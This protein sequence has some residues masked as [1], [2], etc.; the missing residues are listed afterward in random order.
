MRLFLYELKKIWRLPLLLIIA[1]ITAMYAYMFLEFY[2]NYSKMGGQ[3]GTTDYCTALMLSELQ[4]EY[5]QTLEPDKR[6]DVEKYYDIWGAELDE[7]IIGNP[8]YAEEGIFSGRDLWEYVELLNN[9]EGSEEWGD[10]TDERWV[11]ATKIYVEFVPELYAPYLY[12]EYQTQTNYALAKMDAL[13]TGNLRK[14]RFAPSISYKL[15]IIA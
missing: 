9:P 5:G 2:I 11:E 4:A 12:G 7:Y 15:K 8:K 14:P 13:S 10:Y 6:I 3:V 1:V